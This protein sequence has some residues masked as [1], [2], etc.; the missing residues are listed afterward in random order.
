MPLQLAGLYGPAGPARQTEESRHITWGTTIESQTLT[1]A[2]FIRTIVDRESLEDLIEANPGLVHVR[3][4]EL[5]GE[6]FRAVLT[7]EQQESRQERDRQIALFFGDDIQDEPTFFAEDLDADMQ[8]PGHAYRPVFLRP[9]TKRAL[10][11]AVRTAPGDVFLE[12]TSVFGNEFEGWLTDAPE[13]SYTV[14]GPEPRRLRSWFATI[15]W[16]RRKRR[17]MVD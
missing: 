17:W 6:T 7:S 9:R 14:V 13:G 2:V 4:S 3:T 1:Q 5:S 16:S 15:R 11:E 12:E 8:H 10:R